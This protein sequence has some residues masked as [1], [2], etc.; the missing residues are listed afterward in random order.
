[1]KLTGHL[2]NRITPQSMVSHCGKAS[3]KVLLWLVFLIFPLENPVASPGFPKPATS[4]LTLLTLQNDKV[5]EP[6]NPLFSD[7]HRKTIANS[8]NMQIATQ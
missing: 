3:M 8:H 7:L 5:P 1:M 6:A 2:E 4:D